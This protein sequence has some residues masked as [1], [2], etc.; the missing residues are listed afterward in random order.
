MK[1]ISRNENGTYT[2]VLH[3]KEEERKQL[4]K[5]AKYLNLN[6]FEAIK[7]SIKLVSWWTKNEIEPDNEPVQAR[8]S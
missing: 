6:D 5:L 4:K 2:V 1:S 8:E 3:L 7:Y